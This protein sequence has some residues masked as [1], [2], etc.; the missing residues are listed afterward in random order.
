MLGPDPAPPVK[1]LQVLA[2]RGRTHHTLEGFL[3]DAAFTSRWEQWDWL[4]AG[5]GHRDGDTVRFTDEDVDHGGKDVRV[6]ETTASQDPGHF[7]ARTH[8]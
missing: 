3:D 1:E 4:V 7:T 5:R 2:V 8:C 6:W